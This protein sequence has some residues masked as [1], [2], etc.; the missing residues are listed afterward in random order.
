MIS[1]TIYNICKK[2][3]MENE[4]NLEQEKLNE[5][6]KK[7]SQRLNRAQLREAGK[8]LTENAKADADTVE[9][10]V[11]CNMGFYVVVAQ[12]VKGRSNPGI[13]TTVNRGK[14][15]KSLLQSHSYFPGL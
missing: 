14:C 3:K 10:K 2:N 6:R 13:R 15:R 11:F 9:T 12:L 4:I 5:A 8:I 7:A 1:K